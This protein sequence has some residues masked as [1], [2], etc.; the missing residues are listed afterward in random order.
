MAAAVAQPSARRRAGRLVPIVRRA[1][2]AFYSIAAV[3]GA[4]RAGRVRVVA[5]HAL[6]YDAPDQIT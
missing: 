5:G 6:A 3:A 1:V 4:A 2:G